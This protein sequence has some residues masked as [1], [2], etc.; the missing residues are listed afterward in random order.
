LRIAQRFFKQSVL[1]AM[2]LPLAAGLSFAQNR[3][4]VEMQR[5]LAI[6]QVEVREL[7]SQQGERF[8]VLEELLKQGLE[9]TRK[10]NQAIAVIERSV[11]QQS[12]SVIKPVTSMS[13]RMDTMTSQLSALRDVVE[14]LNTRMGRMQ[15]QMEDIQNHLTT[16]PPPSIE[17]GAA[18]TTSVGSAETLYNSALTDF[19]RGNYDLAQAQFSEYLR[20]YPQSGRAA[21]AQYY[22]GDISY[23]KRDYPA[24]ISNYDLVLER[25]PEGTKSPDAQYKKGLALL[26][27]NKLPEAAAEFRSVVEKY[28]SSNIA[29]NAK[30]Q[31][32][33]LQSADQSKPS[34]TRRS[35][36]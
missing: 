20:L 16:I 10:L 9:T 17:G 15:Q 23:Q 1:F 30:A 13:T 18:A 3:Q 28:P 24:A 19:H 29:P 26:M 6:L 31:L 8:A 7:K 33:E 35:A 25:Y 22:V 32:D 4:Q 2:A 34:P 27:L 5:D 21:E 36:R 14:A 11:S 12:D